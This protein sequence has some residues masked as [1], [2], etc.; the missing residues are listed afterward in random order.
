MGHASGEFMEP[1]VQAMR[2]DLLTATYLQVDE[3]TFPCRCTI[4]AA[5]ITKPTYGTNLVAVGAGSDPD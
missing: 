2:K 5:P 4:A 3:T 1:V